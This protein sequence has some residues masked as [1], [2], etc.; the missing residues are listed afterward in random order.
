MIKS[1]D[2]EHVIHYGEDALIMINKNNSPNGT[3]VCHKILNEEFPH[4]ELVSQL[5]NE[6]EICSVAKAECIRKVI[7]KTKVDNHTSITLEFIDGT[8]LNDLLQKNT[9]ATISDKLILADKLAVAV[10]EMHRE[11]IIHAQLNPTN[12][13]LEYITNKV[14]I[15]DFGIASKQNNTNVEQTFLKHSDIESLRYISPEQ[16]GRINR[17]I[18][19]RSDL[20]SLGVLFYK[21]FTGQTPFETNDPM[22][23]V[24]CHIAQTPVAPMVVNSQVPKIVSDIIMKLLAK[25]AEDRYQ[26]AFGV[27]H[28]LE[29]CIGHM[30]S[31][32]DPD[33]IE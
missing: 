26:S 21:L 17:N 12:I 30:K 11:N 13:I 10:S 8:D 28:D 18:D 24:Y 31:G 25:N 1:I 22:E 4:A 15:I 14:F 20:Y 5:E 29:A 19:I 2:R 27:H 9:V 33:T 32:I 6:F 16:T 23:L 3:I 7:Q